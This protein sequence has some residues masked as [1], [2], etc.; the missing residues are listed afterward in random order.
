V[1]GGRSPLRV[2]LCRW[3]QT[4]HMRHKIDSER[5]FRHRSYRNVRAER[6]LLAL[7]HFF[8]RYPVS[9]RR[10]GYL[11]NL[12]LKRKNEARL[13]GACMRGILASMNRERG[14]RSSFHQYG[15]YFLRTT[16]VQGTTASSRPFMQKP[17]WKPKNSHMSRLKRLCK[18]RLISSQTF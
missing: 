8:L 12:A 18:E 17:P 4:R 3:R 11:V 16:G 15:Y 9:S 5:A 6:E 13:P 2:S 1:A 14:N 7:H 10:H